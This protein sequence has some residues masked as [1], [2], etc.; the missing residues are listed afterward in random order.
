MRFTVTRRALHRALALVNHAAVRGTPALP[1]LAF[2]RVEV[3]PDL[4]LLKLQATN[5]QI[6]V[7]AWAAIAKADTPGALAMPAKL[8]TDLVSSVQEGDLTFVIDPDVWKIQLTHPNGEFSFMGQSA[9][10]YPPLPL[11]APGA[12]MVSVPAV[13]FARAVRSV[14]VSLARD[15]SRPVLACVLLQGA[16]ERLILATA[17]GRRVSESTVVLA[18]G[19]DA[20]RLGNR[21]IPGRALAELASVFPTDTS[22]QLSLTPDCSQAL[23]ATPHLVC[24]AILVGGE[25]PNYRAVIPP[26]RPLRV[27]VSTEDFSQVVQQVRIFT[28]GEQRAARFVIQPGAGITPGSLTLSTKNEVGNARNTLSA[29]VRGEP[30]T[31]PFDVH[32][33]HEALQTISTPKVVLEIGQATAARTPAPAG[34]LMPVGGDDLHA[35]MSMKA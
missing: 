34:I 2:L 10:E 16:M 35:F 23:F 32:L 20:S 18:P 15:D 25:F 21:L 26:E 33:I 29:L 17:D 13:P 19:Q 24:S 31:L 3:E 8:L 22:L 9:G 4:T 28:G 14:E 12:P 27:E 1:L 30:T 6:S 5:L 11:P 7:S